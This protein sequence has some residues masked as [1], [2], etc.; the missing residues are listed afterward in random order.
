ML[1]G[2][3]IELGVSELETLPEKHVHGRSR[4]LA[5]RLGPIEVTY[6]RDWRES[7]I[8]QDRIERQGRSKYWG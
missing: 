5:Q 6:H 3:G 7:E 8:A 1:V 4:D 2:R